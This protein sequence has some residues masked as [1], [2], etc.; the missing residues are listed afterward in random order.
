MSGPEKRPDDRLPWILAAA[1]L[2]G[3]GLLLCCLA[4]GVILFFVN[5]PVDT[6]FQQPLEVVP[7]A[8]LDESPGGRVCEAAGAQVVLQ[9]GLL[10]DSDMRFDM[11]MRKQGLLLGL[12]PV[13]QVVP[14][15]MPV[16]P[17]GVLPQV[18]R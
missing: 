12:P 5:L 17:L 13:D 2:F 10:P 18:L 4:V 3:G 14:G 7:A 15:D 9:P 11:A 6:G 8:V 1:I 16:I